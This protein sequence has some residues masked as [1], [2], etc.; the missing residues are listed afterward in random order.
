MEE[1]KKRYSANAQSVLVWR[2]RSL[3][4]RSLGIAL[5]LSWQVDRQQLFGEAQG[6][7]HEM[8][9]EKVR[10]AEAQHSASHYRN[11]LNSYM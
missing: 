4:S 8:R 3:G 11:L 2:C 5:P 1:Q 7:E 9:D 6:V 10:K